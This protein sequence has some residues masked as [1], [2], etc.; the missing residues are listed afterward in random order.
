MALFEDVHFGLRA[1]AKNPGFTATAVV[2][3]ALGIGANATVFGIADAVIFKGM[4]FIDDRIM[5]LSSRNVSRGQQRMGI[6]WPDFRDWGQ[7][8][9]MD[10]LS[11]FQFNVAN[12]SDKSGLPTRYN[13]ASINA[14]T[15]S[16]IGQK[17]IIG[18]DFT[19]EDEKAGATPV[20]IL[21]HGV[22]ENRF[23]KDKNILGKTIRI[24]E[25]TTTIIGVMQDAL[26]F[27]YGSDMWIALRPDDNFEKRQNHFFG[28][29]G[30]LAPGTTEKSAA[31]E[32]SGIARNLQVAYPATNEGV[33]TVVHTQNEDLNG[34][35][36]TLLMFALMG[37]VGFVLL[38]AC[39]NVANLLLARAVDR[40]RE[41]S[42]RIALGAGR[43]RIV[44]QLLVESMMLSILGGVFG[45]L[46]SIWGLKVF[47]ASVRDRIPPWMN[48]S[49]DWRGFAFLGAITLAT[50][51]LFGL[52]PAL[53]LSRLDVNTSLKDQSRGSG[54]G[55]RGRYLSGVLVVVEM[56]LAVV[57]LAG[58]GLMIR[59]FMN[60][61][62][63][64]TGV[65]AK[66]VLVM[67]LFLPEARYP[68]DADQIDFHDRLKARL[69]ALPGVQ[70][71]SISIT[72]PTGGAM[73]MPYELEGAPPADEKRRPTV[74]ELVISPDY[75][76]A[77]DVKIQRGR[78]F[79]DADGAAGLPVV[80]VNQRFAEKFWPGQDPIGKRFR[81][82][83]QQ[84]AGAWL[85]VVGVVPDIL[86][87]LPDQ[88]ATREL[89]ALIYVPFKQ[90]TMRDMSVMARTTVPPNS[91]GTA[92]RKE[93]AAID[94]DLILYNLRSLEERL[95]QNNWPQKVFGSLFATFAVIA[96]VLACV[97][98]YAVIAHSVC[99]R[100]QE[101]GLRIAL[102]ASGSAILRLI[103]M[104]GM[105]QLL[106]GLVAGIA[107][108][109]GLTRVLV[110]LLIDVSPRDPVTFLTVAVMLGS[111]AFLGCLVPAR[112]A[113]RVDPV[114]ALRN[115]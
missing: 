115:E 41:I 103:L 7:V 84:K 5:F 15:F 112:R 71:S 28:A 37:A 16:T 100:T 14:N 31:A 8:K 6:S 79:N 93:V 9:S 42:I 63:M 77:M 67:R 26:T 39:A 65:N 90:K 76:R 58:A 82:F 75:F 55:R 2:A 33:E 57:L 91:L 62:T 4:P 113:M 85:T 101:I 25:V 52:A 66:N 60:M 61:Y 40:A 96:L 19:G 43:W 111:A 21:G 13:V 10:S 81:T 53:R 12:V 114:V 27:P 44:R 107:A 45:W 11:L 1:M 98:L 20:V 48:F 23:G 30:R 36:V 50:G 29:I 54:T 108:A 32:M 102:G 94:E 64:K 106:I 68:K 99:Q 22:W 56:A 24:N 110:S 3:L 51:L 70:V 47:D 46:I 18:R 86:Q 78:T 72:M 59:S 34:P 88:N 69:D 105:G 83:D 49:I 35:E 95:D 104:Q 73:D 97:G 87:N 80:I 109:I 38:I 17:P 92:F 74:G 89:T